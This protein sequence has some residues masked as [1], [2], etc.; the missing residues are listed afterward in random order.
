M[1]SLFASYHFLF[2]V[3]DTMI[4]S[5]EASDIHSL[6]SG[7]VVSSIASLVKELLENSVDAK[8]KRLVNLWLS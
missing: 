6:C 1:G 7:Q 8:G 3:S 5:L 4:K 2:S